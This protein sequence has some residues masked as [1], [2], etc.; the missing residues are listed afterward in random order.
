MESLHLMS[1]DFKAGYAL[2]P[3]KIAAE[4]VA[5]AVDDGESNEKSFSV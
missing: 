1:F 4:V 2:Y 5:Y 3:F